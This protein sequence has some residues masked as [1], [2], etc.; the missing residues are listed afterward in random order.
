MENPIKEELWK[1]T[2]S[3]LNEDEGW[4]LESSSEE[5]K[6]YSKTLFDQYD[7]SAFKATMTLKRP[8][9]LAFEAFLDHESRPKYNEYIKHTKKIYTG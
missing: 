2:L 3:E 7:V 8:I 5:M 9:D 1:M 6:V 4:Y